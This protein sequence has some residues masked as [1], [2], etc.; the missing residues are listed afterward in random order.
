MDNINDYLQILEDKKDNIKRKIR[1]IENLKSEINKL[2]DKIETL[3]YSK[4]PTYKIGIWN[5]NLTRKVT[6]N[7]VYVYDYEE[8]VVDKKGNYEDLIDISTSVLVKVLWDSIE[9]YST[10]IKNIEKSIEIE[11]NNNT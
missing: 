2:Q 8:V 3:E 9:R 10:E 4:I 11:M 6:E 7:R 5:E 1:L